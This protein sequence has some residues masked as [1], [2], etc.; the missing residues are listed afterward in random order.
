VKIGK[1]VDLLVIGEAN[2]APCA[3]SPGDG[4]K[5]RAVWRPLDIESLLLSL[6]SEKDPLLVDGPS[7]LSGLDQWL[8]EMEK[9]T[10]DCNTLRRALY[11]QGTAV[12][13]A[14]QEIRRTLNEI[15][16]YARKVESTPADWQDTAT[17]VQQIIRN[18]EFLGGLLE[19][20]EWGTPR[21]K[22]V[23]PSNLS[24]I[25]LS[26]EIEGEL[27]AYRLQAKDKG[28]TFDVRFTGGVPSKLRTDRLRLRQL[29]RNLVTNAIRTT[30]QGSV[31]VL[32]DYASGN[33][34]FTIV[35]TGPEIPAEA[36]SALETLEPGKQAISGDF[37]SV[38][39][40]YFS[41]RRVAR[42][43]GG[44]VELVSSRAGEGS[45]LRATVR[46]EVVNRPS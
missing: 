8:R 21:E 19:E 35:D 44:D 12:T 26:E 31:R 3:L 22:T 4:L 30:E 45:I 33:L 28:L 23:L 7:L 24:E 37:G 2:E 5:I 32:I 36:R 42:L 20:M 17:Y 41:A 39:L 15:T 25:C 27:E 18:A 10:D 38:G 34:Q 29:M 9:Q 14:I 6:Q 11:E 1:E 43:M 16:W 40:G 46:A 13:C